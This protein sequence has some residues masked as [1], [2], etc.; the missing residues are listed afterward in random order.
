MK[1]LLSRS[2]L[3][4]IIGKHY[5]PLPELCDKALLA[6]AVPQLAS[7]YCGAIRPEPYALSPIPDRHKIFSAFNL[8]RVVKKGR[9]GKDKST[10]G[11][12]W[13]D[14]DP[15]AVLLNKT[16]IRSCHSL[17]SGDFKQ[18]GNFNYMYCPYVATLFANY[19]SPRETEPV[20]AVSAGN[21]V[22]I[23][24]NAVFLRQ[25]QAVANVFIMLSEDNDPFA[26][27]SRVYDSCAEYP[28][29]HTFY[30]YMETRCKRLGIGLAVGEPLLKYCE[31][32]PSLRVL[33]T[34][35]FDGFAKNRYFDFFG[36]YGMSL[37]C[38]TKGLLSF[39]V[40]AYPVLEPT[41]RIHIGAPISDTGGRLI[42]YS[43][44]RLVCSK[45]NGI[46][47]RLFAASGGI[48]VCVDCLASTTE[49]CNCCGLVVASNNAIHI[50]SANRSTLNI[51]TIACCERC[52]P[53]YGHCAWC[54]LYYLPGDE[55][56][57]VK[58][59]DR[60]G[61]IN[62]CNACTSNIQVYT[63]KDCGLKI[64][65]N[66]E[67]CYDCYVVYEN[68][69][70]LIDREADYNR[71]YTERGLRLREKQAMAQSH[72]AT[73]GCGDAWCPGTAART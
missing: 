5:N 7:T 12:V 48:K 59:A 16:T 25:H 42:R 43:D 35:V 37:V 23:N 9:S 41:V 54:G 46:F 64:S 21:Q 19:K 66:R 69:R 68:R 8:T 72:P 20:L 15:L 22:V 1:P 14:T 47:P 32:T 70:Q 73:C 31:Y 39:N 63:C 51:E 33:S 44:P 29:D 71:V 36:D 49:E 67:R 40:D 30:R 11:Y 55:D 2:R 6:Q 28:W 24:G 10:K 3:D 62:L 56:V 60:S 65:D 52:Y 57:K 17:G 26:Y 34:P 27:L 18:G 58:S 4:D 53:K 50:S 13:L 45:C 38:D 61:Y